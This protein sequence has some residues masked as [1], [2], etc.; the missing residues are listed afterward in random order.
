LRNA[1]L[2]FPA[3]DNVNLGKKKKKEE[4]YSVYAATHRLYKCVFGMPR[5]GYE[6]FYMPEE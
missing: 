1:I 3:A 4:E 6:V 5:T 2:V